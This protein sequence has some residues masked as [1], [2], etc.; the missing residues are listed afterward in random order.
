VKKLVVYVNKADMVE[1]PEI[2]ELVRILRW[3][4]GAVV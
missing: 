3:Y 4:S 1:D 2:L